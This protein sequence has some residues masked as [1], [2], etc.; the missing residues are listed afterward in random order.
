MDL[1][2][3]RRRHAVSLRAGREPAAVGFWKAIGRVCGFLLRRRADRSQAEV[4]SI[5]HSPYARRWFHDRGWRRGH[6]FLER[7]KLR[8]TAGF[9]WRWR[10]ASVSLLSLQ[11]LALLI[12]PLQVLLHL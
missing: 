11:L 2:G 8:R 3:R 6:F 12:H 9:L 10:L 7:M 1:P 4:Q 5:N